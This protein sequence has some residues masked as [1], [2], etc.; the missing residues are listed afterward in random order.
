LGEAVLDATAADTDGLSFGHLR[1]IETLSGLRAVAAGRSDRTPVDVSDAVT[2]VVEGHK[3]AGDGF[4]PPPGS[5]FGLRPTRSRRGR[6]RSSV[7]EDDI[8]F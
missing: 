1:E 6:H 4:A 8:P 5:E 3:R 7:S 2:L